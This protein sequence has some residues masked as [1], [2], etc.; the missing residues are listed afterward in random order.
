M[1]KV[2]VLVA[3]MN[4]KDHSLLQKMNIHSDVLVGNQCDENKIEHFIYGNNKASY[5]SFAEKGVGLNRNNLLMRATGDICLFADDDMRYVDDYVNVVKETFRKCPDAD[6]IVFNLIEKVPERYIIRKCARVRF[7]NYLRY[8]TARIAVR[9]KRIR[10]EGIFFH[11][12]YGGGTEHCHGEDNLF[13]TECLR[14]GLKIYAMPVYIAE[15]LE[16]RESTWNR[17]YDDSYLKDQGCLYYAISKKIWKLL[18]FQDA[19]RHTKLYHMPAIC[20]YK[21]MTKK[22][23][24]KDKN[25]IC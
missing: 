25:E 17:K 20:A 22:G 4:Q 3:T 10:E 14:H 23:Q 7:Y 5:Y 19:I 2:Q 16:D 11:L 18:C 21:K 13:L 15:L 8:G 6:V 1:D 9:T 24:N 12:C